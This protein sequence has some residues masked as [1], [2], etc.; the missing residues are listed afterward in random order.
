M[1]EE[2]YKWLLNEG[3]PKMI[4]EALKLYGI[5]ELPGNADNP[6]I[7]SWA[8]E[9]GLPRVYSHDEIP[10]CGLFMA[11]I[12]KRAGKKLP[13]DPLWALNWVN[14]GNPVHIAM[15]GDVLVFKR[16]QGGHVGMYV[17]EDD[18]SYHTFA[19]NQS[20][21]VNIKRISKVRCVG[22]RRPDYLIGQP[23]NVRVIHLLPDSS[24]S[25]NEQ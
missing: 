10:W 15:L 12:A 2:K 25:Q 6:E 4:V 19:G 7:L 14:F 20:D 8:I 17:G 23:A 9:L 3:A 21:A 16:S 18:D 13:K 22:V 5:K 24:E 1:I 11:I